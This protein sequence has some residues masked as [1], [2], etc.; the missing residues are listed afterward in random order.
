M[1]SPWKTI[2]WSQFGASIDTSMICSVPVLI[3]YGAKD[4]GKLHWHDLSMPSFGIE[5]ITPY[6]GSN[7]T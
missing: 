5:S 1:N 4:S 3:S 6:S 7:C 2:I